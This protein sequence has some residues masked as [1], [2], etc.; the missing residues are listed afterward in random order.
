MLSGPGVKPA[1]SRSVNVAA[2]RCE[3]LGSCCAAARVS[4]S[5]SAR[6]MARGKVGS[7]VELLQAARSPVWETE[8]GDN[9]APLFWWESP[10]LPLR[11]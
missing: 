3:A 5:F 7:I 11:C 8:D 1:S 6:E 10:P 4:V 9:T 2:G